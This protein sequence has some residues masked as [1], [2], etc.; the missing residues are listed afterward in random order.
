[1]GGLPATYGADGDRT[2]PKTPRGR[3][4]RRYEGGATTLGAFGVRPPPMSIA[5]E[6]RVSH[7]LV[8]KYIFYFLLYFF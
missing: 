8:F 2:T 5:D 7:P 3:P 6:D 4:P 1:M